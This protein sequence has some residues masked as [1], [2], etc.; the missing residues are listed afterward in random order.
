MLSRGERRRGRRK[1]QI[2]RPLSESVLLF[3]EMPKGRLARSQIDLS[4]DIDRKKYYIFL[5]AFYWG[6]A[7][8]FVGRSYLYI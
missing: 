1:I 6:T 2:L 4:K 8:F 3:E 5:G 7:F